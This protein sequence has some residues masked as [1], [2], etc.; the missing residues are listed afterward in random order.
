[1]ASCFAKRGIRGFDP[2][3]RNVLDLG[4][5]LRLKELTH[6]PVIVDPSHATGRRS[7]IEP[8]V[9]AAAAAGLDGAIDLE[10][11]PHPDAALSDAAQAIDCPTFARIARGAA[12]VCATLTYELSA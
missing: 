5:A 12:R 2:S 8:L 7:L 6:L 11:H 10:L 9:L 1:M 3:T 4:G